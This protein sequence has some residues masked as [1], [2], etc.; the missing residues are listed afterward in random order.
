MSEPRRSGGV[1]AYISGRSLRAPIDERVGSS[2]PV[3]ARATPPGVRVLLVLLALLAVATTGHAAQLGYVGNSNGSVSVFDTSNDQLVKII[4]LGIEARLPNVSFVL[5]PSSRRLFVLAEEG[6]AS[7]GVS[8]T[9]V[10]NTLSLIDTTSHRVVARAVFDNPV[11]L[12]DLSAFGLAQTGIVLGADASVVYV[13]KTILLQAF[14][15]TT[16]VWRFDPTTLQELTRLERS[17]TGFALTT[18]APTRGLLYAENATGDGIEVIDAASGETVQEVALTGN[19]SPPA[20]DPSALLGGEAQIK[21]SPDE[22]T[23]LLRD[24]VVDLQSG[25]PIGRLPPFVSTRRFSPDSGTLLAVISAPQPPSSEPGQGSCRAT[26]FQ[27]DLVRLDLRTFETVASA[28][29]GQTPAPP[30][31]ASASADGRLV[32]VALVSCAEPTQLGLGLVDTL[33]GVVLQRTAW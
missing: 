12:L 20:P 13:V 19:V 24:A 11:P 4:P 18:L 3:A 27:A 15:P 21:V 14:F 1:R 31:I 26:R 29:L 16:F 17:S 9:L 10:R 6:I 22:R 8:P 32:G 5:S 2:D 7:S 25:L 33:M 28:P 30:T 23:L